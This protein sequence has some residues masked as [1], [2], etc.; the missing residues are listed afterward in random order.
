MSSLG[1]QR[2]GCRKLWS[3][4]LHYIPCGTPNAVKDFF[5]CIDSSWSLSARVTHGGSHLPGATM[6]STLHRQTV[7]AL[8]IARRRL[9][10]QGCSACLR[11]SS[12]RIPCRFSNPWF[13]R[14]S[15][16]WHPNLPTK[17]ALPI[18]H[19][20][21]PIRSLSLG[22]ARFESQTDTRNHRVLATW[23]F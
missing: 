17:L 10:Q 19:F 12:Q 7:E 3:C 11:A 5:G 1:D 20:E 6:K 9:F 21:S 13:G 2:M 14:W 16:D 15:N 4:G 22:S 18:R 8:A 23:L